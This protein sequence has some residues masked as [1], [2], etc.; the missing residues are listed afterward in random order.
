[1][2]HRCINL[3]ITGL[4]VVAFASTAFAQQQQP[5]PG[6]NPPLPTMA[7]LQQMYDNGDYPAA[8]QQIARVLRLRGAPAEPYNRDALL[9]LRGKTLLAMDD[10]RAAR[11]AFEEA[12]KSEQPEVAMVASGYVTLLSRSKLSIYTPR[13]GDK[14][15]INISDPKN[16]PNAFLALLEDELP[17]CETDAAAAAKADNLNPAIALVPKLLELASVEYAA[18][19]KY[20]RVQPIAKNV[21][22]HA[23]ALIG[24]ELAAQDQKITAIENMANQLLDTGGYRGGGRGGRR[25]GWWNSD[26]TRRGLVSDERESLYQLAE[27]LQKVEDTARRGLSVAQAV[28]GETADWQTVVS[29]AERVKNHAQYVLEAEGVRTATDTSNR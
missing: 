18:T 7:E 5:Q 27:Y 6:V 9:V 24:N 14:T 3:I 2:R 26:V 25:G 16:Q 20:E 22:V 17:A 4:F 11:R 12:R 1:M 19:G 23:R 10:P 8:V 29:E 28:N 15:S 21:G 13:T